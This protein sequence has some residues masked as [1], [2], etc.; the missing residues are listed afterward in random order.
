[1][2]EGISGFVRLGYIMV[3]IC[4]VRRF[5]SGGEK[6]KWHKNWAGTGA[7]KPVT[8]GGAGRAEQWTLLRPGGVEINYIYIPRNPKPP[9]VPDAH[10]GARGGTGP[11][12][13]GDC[14]VGV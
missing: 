13:P 9:K 3:I 11:K 10:P 2:G 7:H 12:I 1:M 8:D 5:M 14:D 6:V 4:C